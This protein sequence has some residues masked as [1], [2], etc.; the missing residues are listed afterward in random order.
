MDGGAFPEETPV[1]VG[2]HGAR[3]LTLRWETTPMPLT[4]S[5]TNG[6][7]DHARA[8]RPAASPV[9]TRPPRGGDTEANRR[10]A[11][12][13]AKQQQAAE[14]IATAT[15]EISAQNAEAA[16]ASR[17]LTDSMQQ[18]SA[19]AEEASG[20]TQ[21]SLAAM[22]QVEERVAAQEQTTRQV[23]ELSQALQNLLNETRAGIS[24]L[25]GNVESAS[26]RQ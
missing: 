4:T 23:A 21:E 13:V 22:N 26:N 9:S 11:R 15:A 6:R 7:A 12:S 3:Q 18:I 5:S 20:A 17:Q 25:L 8:T 24:G 19:G 14:R 10:Q 2:V 16:E 1:T